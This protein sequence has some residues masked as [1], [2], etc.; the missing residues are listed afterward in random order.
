MQGLRRELQQGGCGSVVPMHAY[1][2]GQTARVAAEPDIEPW[3]ASV[4]GRAVRPKP[5]GQRQATGRLRNARLSLDGSTPSA[6]IAR[7]RW[8]RSRALSSGISG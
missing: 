3:R 7:A 6:S 4:F 8:C 1:S 5:S 2:D